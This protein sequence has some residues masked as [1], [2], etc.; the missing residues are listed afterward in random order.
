VADDDSSADLLSAAAEEKDRR[1]VAAAT[2]E[3]P[4]HVVAAAV[5]RERPEAK[6]AMR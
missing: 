6:D 5:F 3:L 4:T 2:G 1:E